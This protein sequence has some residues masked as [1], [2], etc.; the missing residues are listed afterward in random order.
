MAPEFITIQQNMVAEGALLP[1]EFRVLLKQSG[2]DKPYAKMLKPL[3]AET[4]RFDWDN[5]ALNE[6][7]SQEECIRSSTLQTVKSDTRF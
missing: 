1:S 7:D 4:F 6:D 5:P 3:E 2:S